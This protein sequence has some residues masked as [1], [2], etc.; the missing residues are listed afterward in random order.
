MQF[1]ASTINSRRYKYVTHRK[2]LFDEL[3][4]ADDEYSNNILFIDRN[5][6]AKQKLD[7]KKAIAG[8]Q[9]LYQFRGETNTSTPATE[10]DPAK[11]NIITTVQPCGCPTCRCGNFNDCP[12]QHLVG[13]LKTHTMQRKSLIDEVPAAVGRQ[14]DNEDEAVLR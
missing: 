12:C 11:Y 2:P 13:P 8:T 5:P 3:K 9:K 4:A 10:T 1:N 14:V 6:M 7:A